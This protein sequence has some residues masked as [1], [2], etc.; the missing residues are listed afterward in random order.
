MKT[1]RPAALCDRAVGS[2]ADAGFNCSMSERRNWTPNASKT[3]VIKRCLEVACQPIVPQRFFAPRPELT[4]NLNVI[5]GGSAMNKEPPCLCLNQLGE[6]VNAD[7]VSAVSETQPK[8]VK[9]LLGANPLAV[10]R[11]GHD[12][13]WLAPRLKER[14]KPGA[15]ANPPGVSGATLSA[16]RDYAAL[17]VGEQ[18][19]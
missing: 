11:R 15:G 1:V 6:C 10:C 13:T 14:R 4:G 18:E 2:A 7:S 19:D 17:C 5:I 8:A 9:R 3:T 16:T 12:R